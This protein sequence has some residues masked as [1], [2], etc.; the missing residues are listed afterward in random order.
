MS[1]RRDHPAERASAQ[2]AGAASLL[3]QGLEAAAVQM[4]DEGTR[5]TRATATA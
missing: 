3:G 5:Q 2:P 4:E 1:D